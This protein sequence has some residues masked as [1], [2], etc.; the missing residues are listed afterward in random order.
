MAE[1]VLSALSFHLIETATLFIG[2]ENEHVIT[3]HLEKLKLPKASALE[4]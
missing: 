2:K 1:I 4:N 3:A